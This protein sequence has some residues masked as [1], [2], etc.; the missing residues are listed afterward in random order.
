M[1]SSDIKGI[2]IGI[3]T[4]IISS[5][6]V[7]IYFNRRLREK[8]EIQFLRNVSTY[9]G[10]IVWIICFNVDNIDAF[11][12]YFNNKPTPIGKIK[13]VKGVET[14]LQEYS[15]GWFEIN[16][17][18]EKCFK[19]NKNDIL[20]WNNCLKKYKESYR[21]GAN[22]LTKIIEN[23]DKTLIFLKLKNKFQKANYH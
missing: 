23:P 11:W 13:Y 8:E 10:E 9:M 7:T 14:I 19:D 16:Q 3:F 20:R 2:I 5:I 15:K 17:M 12:T 6:L 21:N 4:G 1:N 18:Y 22:Q